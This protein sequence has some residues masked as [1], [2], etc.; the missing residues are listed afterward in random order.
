MVTAGLFRTICVI[1]DH[2]IKTD[3]VLSEGLPGPFEQRCCIRAIENSTA[4]GFDCIQPSPPS[5]RHG[6][7]ER[8]LPK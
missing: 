7:R 4:V 8:R 5:R 2:N 3:V 1:Q 6:W